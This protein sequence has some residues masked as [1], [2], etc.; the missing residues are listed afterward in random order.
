MA[1]EVMIR[2]RYGGNNECDHES[3]DYTWKMQPVFRL[4]NPKSGT[5]LYACQACIDTHMPEYSLITRALVSQYDEEEHKI[6]NDNT[7]RWNSS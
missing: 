3:H 5:Y 2:T 6:R 7:K 4:Y 1:L